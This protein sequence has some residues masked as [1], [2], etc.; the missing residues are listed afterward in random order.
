[1]R[2][3]RQVRTYPEKR[4]INFFDKRANLGLTVRAV[5]MTINMTIKF[6]LSAMCGKAHQVLWRSRQM[7]PGNVEG[8]F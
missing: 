8:I 5:N 2:A 3:G 1:M 6:S 4:I 7:A